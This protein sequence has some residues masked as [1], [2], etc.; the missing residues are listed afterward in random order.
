MIGLD[1]VVLWSWFWWDVGMY[2]VTAGLL[3]FMT[4]G[5]LLPFDGNIIRPIKGLFLF[6]GIGLVVF[7]FMA[8]GAA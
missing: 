1:S 6:G 5:M 4:F 8:I 3:S 7:G 2:S